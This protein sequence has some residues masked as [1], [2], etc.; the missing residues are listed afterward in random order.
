[1]KSHTFVYVG[2]CVSSFSF[3][4]LA[5]YVEIEA[6]VRFV[7]SYIGMMAVNLA[8]FVLYIMLQRA[9]REWL[10]T[11][12]QC[13]WI[14]VCIAIT[15]CGTSSTQI[16]KAPSES[17]VFPL[18]IIYDPHLWGHLRA[19]AILSLTSGVLTGELTA[20]RLGQGGKQPP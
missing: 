8:V 10:S 13:V 14:L 3:S 20:R 5:A 16:E 18:A 1:M 11:R 12:I 4:T 7:D 19:A 2:V 6:K 15:T 17:E 9:D